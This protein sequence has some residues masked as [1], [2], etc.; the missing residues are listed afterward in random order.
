MFTRW[1]HYLLAAMLGFALLLAIL[2]ALAAVLV[3]PNLPS[4]ETLTDYQPKIPLRIYT[5]DNALIGEFGEERRA[6][7]K[8]DAVPLLMRQAILAAEDERFYQHGGVDY[9]GVLRAAVANLSSGGARPASRVAAARR[10]RKRPA[11]GN[12]SRRRPPPAGRASVRD[13]A[14]SGRLHRAFGGG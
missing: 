7:V 4:L 1:W 3:F 2:F 10:P 11:H 14:S 6:L 8:I 12:R 9:I 5:A 13:R